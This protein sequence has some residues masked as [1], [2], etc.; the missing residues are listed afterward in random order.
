MIRT[1]FISS[2]HEAILGLLPTPHPVLD[3]QI[4]L[5][6]LKMVPNDSPWP[7]HWV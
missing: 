4:E 6:L 3:I 1:Q 7:K 5:R 2:L